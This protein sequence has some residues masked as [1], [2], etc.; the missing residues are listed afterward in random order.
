MSERVRERERESEMNERERIMTGYKV[1]EGEEIRTHAKAGG[2]SDSGKLP[3]RSTGLF[4]WE[5]M[6]THAIYAWRGC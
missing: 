6:H 1:D 5:R 2:R 4:S 3:V